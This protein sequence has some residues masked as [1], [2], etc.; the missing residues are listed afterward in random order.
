MARLVHA[1]GKNYR[2]EREGRVVFV[3]V[4]KRADLDS[5]EGA[6]LAEQVEGQLIAL[7]GGK[8]SLVVDVRRAPEVNGPRTTGSIG[9]IV[10]AWRRCRV[11][12]I[13]PNVAITQLQLKRLIESHGATNARVFAQPEEALAW[14]SAP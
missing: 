11:A 6:K 4:W 9:R 3:E 12:F 10:A 13:C 2:I 5:E 1:E 8:R 14:T 7:A